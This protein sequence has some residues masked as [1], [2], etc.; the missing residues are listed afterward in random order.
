MRSNNDYGFISYTDNDAS[1][2]LVQLGVQRTA[3][4]TGDLIIYTN[5]GNTSA[6][7]RVRITSAGNVQIANGNLVFSTAGKGIDFSANANAAGMS[8]E[9]LDDYEEG[10]FTPS[11][12]FNGSDL[13]VVYSTRTGRY[14]KIGNRVFFNILLN[15][16]NKGTATGVATIAGL[17]FT[18]GS[19]NQGYGAAVG[20]DISGITF[21]NI[22]TYRIVGGST[23]ITLI[24]NGGTGIT[25]ADF[26]NASQQIVSGHY[27]V[28]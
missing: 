16:S 22:I 2:D 25:A 1:E 23:S 24:E 11:I 12:A 18:V 15:T 13:G 5:A 3:A 4:D 26:T 9:L 17:P 8:S 14:T 10:S 7:E 19:G 21:D 6:T 20:A 28:D 27:Y